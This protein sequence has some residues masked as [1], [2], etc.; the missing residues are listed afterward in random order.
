MKTVLKIYLALVIMISLG[1]LGLKG[2]DYFELKKVAKA[3]GGM[4]AQFGGMIT[5]YSPRCVSDPMT[6]VCAN[7]PTCTTPV[8]GVGNFVCNGYQE[9][10]FTPAGGTIGPSGPISNVCVPAVFPYQGGGTIPRVGGYILGG[11]ASNIIPWVI[12][13]S[14]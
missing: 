8:T 4:P 10:D 6:G 12:G 2:K 13:I 7:C 3:A 9:I 11:G 14:N 5:Y 1:F